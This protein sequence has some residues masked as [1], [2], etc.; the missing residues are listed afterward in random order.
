M[1]ADAAKHPTAAATI[2]IAKRPAGVTFFP[3]LREVQQPAAQLGIHL[4]QAHRELAV[5]GRAEAGQELVESVPTEPLQE[6]ILVGRCPVYEP[7]PVLFADKESAVVEAPHDRHDRGVGGRAGAVLRERCG[8]RGH[9]CVALLPDGVHHRRAERPEDVV[10]RWI[11]GGVRGG[12]G[13]TLL[14]IASG[15]FIRHGCRRMP[16]IT[17]PEG[18][19]RRV[20]PR[21]GTC[22]RADSPSA[23]PRPKG[24]ARG[25]APTR[26]LQHLEAQSM[27]EA[28]AGRWSRTHRHLRPAALAVVLGVLNVAVAVPALGASPGPGGDPRS[29]GEGPGFAGDPGTAIV[30]VLGLGLGT[31]LVTTIY[32]RLTG[33][34]RTER[35]S[36]DHAGSADIE[37]SEDTT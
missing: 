21:G 35:P 3:A 17:R 8:H 5:S 14:P 11:A 28:D 4:V 20:P 9:G 19:C 25:G 36:D 32:L 16:R 15:L 2:N 26:R 23:A 7:S 6:G 30:A 33:G 24:S 10:N 29:A 22:P 1:A 13:S 27:S 18:R 31:T 12:H 34:R 37:R